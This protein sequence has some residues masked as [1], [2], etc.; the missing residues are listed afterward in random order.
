MIHKGSGDGEF[1]NPGPSKRSERKELGI[2]GLILFEVSMGL[3][4][5]NDGML[6]HPNVPKRSC[7]P[8]STSISSIHSTHTSSPKLREMPRMCLE[9]PCSHALRNSSGQELDCWRFAHMCELS[10]YAVSS[11]TA[12]AGSDSHFFGSIPHQG[13]AIWW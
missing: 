12:V 2:R 4:S 5:A 10:K 6:N 11:V 3:L 8:Q 1:I 7:L 13:C 9:P